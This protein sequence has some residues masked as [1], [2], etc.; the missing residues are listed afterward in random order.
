MSAKPTYI[1]SSG[2]IATAPLRVRAI[3]VGQDYITLVYLFFVTL[4]SVRP[5]PSF[6][7]GWGLLPPR[8]YVPLR[9]PWMDK[10]SWHAATS[11]PQLSFLL[12]V[13]AQQYT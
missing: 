12:Y 3:R 1:S 2:S 4:L 9:C 7:L 5:F 6:Q 11:H 10:T 8:C 13:A